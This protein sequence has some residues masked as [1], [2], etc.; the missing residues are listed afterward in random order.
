MIKFFSCQKHGVSRRKMLTIIIKATEILQKL[1]EAGHNPVK[2]PKKRVSLFKSC[3][4]RL[5]KDKLI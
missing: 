5:D 1:I 4:I 2:L 3:L